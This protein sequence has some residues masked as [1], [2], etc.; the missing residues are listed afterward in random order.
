MKV[1]RNQHSTVLTQ[2]EISEGEENDDREGDEDDDR[3]DSLLG[4]EAFSTGVRNQ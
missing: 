1:L 2:N 4:S 3:L